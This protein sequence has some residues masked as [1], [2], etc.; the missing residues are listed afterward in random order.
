MLYDVFM[1]SVVIIVSGMICFIIGMLYGESG[2]PSVRSW[3][4]D[5]IRNVKEEKAFLK[6]NPICIKCK[7]K[8]KLTKARHMWKWTYVDGVS[9]V[10]LCYACMM[11]EMHKDYG[12]KV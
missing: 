3:L 11:E 5:E 1:F 12:K 7:Q 4:K 2:R 8:G 6:A 9:P 10:P